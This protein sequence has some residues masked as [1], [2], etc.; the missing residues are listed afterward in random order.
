VL[1]VLLLLLLQVL[2]V[3]L[4]VVLLLVLLLLVR[5]GWRSRL[6]WVLRVVVVVAR[7]RGRCLGPGW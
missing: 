1:L 4:L 6:R 3:L 5:R 2:V 7:V